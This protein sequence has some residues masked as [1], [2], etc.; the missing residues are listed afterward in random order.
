MKLK[1]LGSAIAA[2]MCTSAGAA[3]LVVNGSG[4]A[5]N[6]AVGSEAR[7]AKFDPSLGELTGVNPG[8]SQ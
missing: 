1:L 6:F 5:T 7:I 8:I 3:T 4:D 2:T